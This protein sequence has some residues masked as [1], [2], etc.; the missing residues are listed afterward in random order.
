[1][2]AR[3]KV[4]RRECRR[5]EALLCKIVA[6]RTGERAAQTILEKDFCLVQAALEADSVVVSLDET[7]REAYRAAAQGVGEIG[8]IV[9][10]N[11]AQEEDGPIEW[12]KSGAMPEKSRRLSVGQR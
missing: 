6:A 3:K 4:V 9:W 1:M 5:D 12:L 7:A 10:V 11:P 2:E 8:D